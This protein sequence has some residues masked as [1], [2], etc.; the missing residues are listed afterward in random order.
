VNWPLLILF[1]V[2]LAGLAYCVR[3]AIMVTKVSVSAHVVRRNRK[4]ELPTHV[5]GVE[6]VRKQAK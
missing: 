4:P 5:D 2:C 1:L 6:F 3:V